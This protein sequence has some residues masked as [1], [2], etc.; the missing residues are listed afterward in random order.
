MLMQ[1]RRQNS[2]LGYG[3]RTREYGKGRL[4]VCFVEFFGFFSLVAAE[5]RIALPSCAMPY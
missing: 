2:N 5:I 1:G 4:V 3:R